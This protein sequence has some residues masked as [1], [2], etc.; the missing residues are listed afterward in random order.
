MP[1]QQNGYMKNDG[2]T[3]RKRLRSFRY[4]FNGIRL[5]IT[6]EH[7][8]WIHCFAAVCVVIAGVLLGLSRMEWVAVVIVI[9]AVLAAEA[10]N[11]ALE[12]IA[13]F[14]SPEY[15]ETDQRPGSR[16]RIVNGDCRR[17]SRRNH[18][19][20]QADCF[21]LNPYVLNKSEH[22]K[23]NRTNNSYFKYSL[24][25]LITHNNETSRRPDDAFQRS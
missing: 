25:I 7:N 23:Q 24:L 8:A 19:F 2:F 6:K 4:A 21:I 3:F 15:S 9:G 11:S 20:S 5:L 12:A 18:L 1:P 14:V 10:V 17:N 22:F 13:D 16:S